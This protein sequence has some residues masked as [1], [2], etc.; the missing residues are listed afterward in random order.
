M[1]DDAEVGSTTPASD[2][3]TSSS[4][5]LASILP[6]AN[7][8]LFFALIL[9]LSY[10][11]HQTQKGQIM[12]QRQERNRIIFATLSLAASFVKTYAEHTLTNNQKKGTL[13]ILL[14]AASKRSE[15][16]AKEVKSRKDRRSF[17]A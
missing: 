10:H 5:L 1:Q 13:D 2:P 15:R 16:K 9:L 4:S 7:T 6:L 12:K 8:I 3:L 11:I 14:E 17:S